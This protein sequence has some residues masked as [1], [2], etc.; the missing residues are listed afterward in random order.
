MEKDLFKN[1]GEKA[2]LLGNEAI[3][4]GA[5]ESDVRFITTYPGTPTSEIGNIFYEYKDKF[6]YYFEFSTNEKVAM[7]SSAGASLCG[8][9]SLVAMKN[10]GLNVASD[11]LYPLVYTGVKGGMVIVVGD[12]PSCHSSAQSEDNTR[13]NILKAH[14]P[15]LE[16]SNPQECKDFTKLA[17]EISEKFSI[18][19]IIRGTTRVLH[20]SGIVILDEIKKIEQKAKFEKDPLRFSTMNAVL[21]HKELLEK[22][23]RIKNFVEKLKINF[24]KNKD[25]SKFGIIASGISYQYIL[26]ILDELNLK[27]PILKLGVFYPLPEKLIKNFIK[28]LKEVLVLEELD[29]ILEKEVE[30]L[31][32][33]SN[34]K[35]KVYGKDLINEF[36]EIR[37]ED[38]L[39]ALSKILNIKLD[40]DYKKH[41]EEI[42]KINI[43]KRT[44][45]FCPNCPYHFVFSTIKRIFPNFIFGGEIGCYMLAYYPPYN[46]QDYLYCMGSSVG[47]AHGINKS[48]KEKVIAFVG[49]S[50]F[51][52]AAIP[53]IIN[54]VYNKSNILIIILDNM[55]TAMTGHQPHPGVDGIKI[56]DVL[57]GIGIKNLKVV[58]PIDIKE[59]EKTLKDFSEKDGVSVIIA[60]H[61]C[62]FIK[63]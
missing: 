25:K 2:F 31:A 33:D 55:T 23:E 48:S 14:I 20:Q 15:A 18:P 13:F 60:R 40:F 4:R 10:F 45:S 37:P 7:E 56:E 59:F 6:D 24:I 34:Y 22:I 30:R 44:P 12:D 9:R 29:P 42:E 62:A 17:F 28:N 32:K 51:F 11:F 19:V 47:V 52:H 39:I 54:A 16:P 27:I 49:D 36:G 50:S 26:E 3:V 58:D 41:K 43:P 38:I 57:N 8:L 53:E 35:L 21:K 5:L 63:R 61:P 1:K 46:M